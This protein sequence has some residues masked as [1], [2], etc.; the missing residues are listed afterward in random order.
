MNKILSQAMSY[1]LVDTKIQFVDA[2]HVKSHAN[3][4][5]T[6]K[7]EVIKQTK[8]YQQ[9]LDKEIGEDRLE[10]NKKPLKPRSKE[11]KTRK[12]IQRNFLP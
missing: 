2:T 4:Y 6:V 11:S 1:G 3:R 9:K 12:Q 8:N 5:K 10:K 7:K